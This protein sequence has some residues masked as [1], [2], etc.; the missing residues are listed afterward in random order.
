ML[1]EINI[2]VSWL[3]YQQRQTEYTALLL[4]SKSTDRL[5][6]A[7]FYSS[8]S[9]STTVR[10]LLSKSTEVLVFKSTWVSRVHL[11][12]IVLLQP[13]CLHFWT[14]MSYMELWNM[15]MLIPFGNVK[16]IES[17]IKSFSSFYHVALFNIWENFRKFKFHGLAHSRDGP[18]AS[19][20][21]VSSMVSSLI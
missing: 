5:P 10:C 19:L 9:K 7:K 2:W 14:E 13:Q 12:N 6:L 11:L 3:L 21:I 16:G 17:K 15:L 4:E 20:S 18:A 8:T 1:R